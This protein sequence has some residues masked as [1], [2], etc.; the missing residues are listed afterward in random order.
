MKRESNQRIYFS[1]S[2]FSWSQMQTVATLCVGCW[3]TRVLSFLGF[4]SSL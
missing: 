2:M 3:N 4:H 1:D